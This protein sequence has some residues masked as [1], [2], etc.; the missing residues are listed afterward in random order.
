MLNVARFNSLVGRTRI[1]FLALAVVASTGSPIHA[2]TPVEFLEVV[3]GKPSN[4]IGHDVELKSEIDARKVSTQLSGPFHFSYA[5][6]CLGRPTEKTKAY[7]TWYKIDRPRDQLRR[8][9]E[10]LDFIRGGDDTSLTIGTAEYLLSPAQRI[11]SGPPSD[12]PEGLDYYKAYQIVE[13]PS[14]NRD[15]VLS[16][17]DGPAKRKVGKAVFLCVAAQQWHHDDFIDASHPR[18]CFVVYE[19]DGQERQQKFSSIDQFGLNQLQTS[20][21]QWLC[22][23]GS[24][25]KKNA[26]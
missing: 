13:A 1:V 22:V 3:E 23:R 15:V 17:S 24:L 11:E 14:Q 10:V 21:S 6:G 18:A 4:L 25:L 5:V 12:V 7:L 8:K 2:H 26:N 16:D 19:L 9:V 20:K